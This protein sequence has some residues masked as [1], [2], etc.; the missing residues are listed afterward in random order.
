MNLKYYLRGLGIGIL[1]TVFIMGFSANNRAAGM[2]DEEIR[3]EALKLGMVDGTDV[4]IRQTDGESVSD[5]QPESGEDAVSEDAASNELSPDASA[6]KDSDSVPADASSADLI[7]EETDADSR[8]TEQKV[9]PETNGA[10]DKNEQSDVKIDGGEN[11]EEENALQ[12]E[13]TQPAEGETVTITVSSG[14]GS[15]RVAGKLAD[16]GLVEDAAQYDRFL[17]QNGYDK[18]LRV[19]NFDIPAG[20]GDL[21]IAKILTG[22]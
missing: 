12:Q 6:D 10:E 4:L 14:D 2:T 17:C 22:R 9:E 16:A 19:G 15:R 3:K 21:E 18:R 13:Q 20:S 1:V 11:R 7:S 5:N 8:E